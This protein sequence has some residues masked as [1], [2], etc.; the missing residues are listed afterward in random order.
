MT[1]YDGRKSG[2]CRRLSRAVHLLPKTPQV[3]AAV[4]VIV[5]TGVETRDSLNLPLPLSPS[6]YLCAVKILALSC[7]HAHIIQLPMHR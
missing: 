1:Y 5:L 3:Q 2:T 7:V 6:D 4:I